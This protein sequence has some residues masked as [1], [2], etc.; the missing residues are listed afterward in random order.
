M[1]AGVGGIAS[2]PVANE[3]GLGVSVRIVDVVLRFW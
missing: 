2:L 1:A 3:D